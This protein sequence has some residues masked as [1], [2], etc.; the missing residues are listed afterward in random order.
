MAE[1]G[2]VDGSHKVKRVWAQC[3][4]SFQTG[5]PLSNRVPRE[6]RII[7]SRG[8]FRRQQDTMIKKGSNSVGPLRILPSLSIF[9][10]CPRERSQGDDSLIRERRCLQVAKEKVC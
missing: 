2:E 4:K 10:E 7:L 8:L 1:L 3:G 9:L 6:T 5:E